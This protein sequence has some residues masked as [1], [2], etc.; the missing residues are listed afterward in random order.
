[1]PERIIE[2]GTPLAYSEE[3]LAGPGTYDDGSQ[4]RAAVFGTQ[5][6]DPETMTLTVVPAGR[7]VATIETEVV[8][9]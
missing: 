4:L 9:A 6:V 3:Y 2:P 5:K 1:M 7:S 8:T